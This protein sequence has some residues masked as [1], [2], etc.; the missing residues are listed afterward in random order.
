MPKPTKRRHPGNGE[1]MLGR[2]HRQPTPTEN[3]R[4]NEN[5]PFENGAIH[6]DYFHRHRNEN[7]ISY[8]SH[9][10]SISARFPLSQ[11][12]WRY[13]P[14]CHGTINHNAFSFMQTVC[15]R[16]RA[17]PLSVAFRRV[18]KS[19][20]TFRPKNAKKRFISVAQLHFRSYCISSSL[21]DTSWSRP[22]FVHI[23]RYAS[24]ASSPPQTFR[25]RWPIH[26]PGPFTP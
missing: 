20:R 24:S 8:R 16:A 5:K 12:R 23:L 6:R 19:A 21:A 9:G 17:R 18:H 3:S 26:L 25:L 22:H 11:Q 10:L 4:G 13:W 15:A 14:N 7:S 2:R 1:Q